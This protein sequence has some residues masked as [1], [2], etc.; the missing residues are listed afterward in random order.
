MAGIKYIDSKSVMNVLFCFIVAVGAAVP[1]ISAILTMIGAICYTTLGLFIPA[2]L[3]T[4][5]LW[6]GGLGY[7]R[8]RLYKNISLMIVALFAL[9]SG[10]YVAVEDIKRSYMK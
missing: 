10:S 7:G 5:T 8:W 1:D 2:M 3:E 6:D 9:I 4:V